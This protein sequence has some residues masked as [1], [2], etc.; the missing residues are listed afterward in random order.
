[1]KKMSYLRSGRLFLKEKLE[2]RK[3]VVFSETEKKFKTS[4]LISGVSSPVDVEINYTS[5][6]D[7][8]L[9]LNN[10]RIVYSSATIG[11]KRYDNLYDRLKEK[12]FNDETLFAP[13]KVDEGY[14]YGRHRAVDYYYSDF[15]RHVLIEKVD[16]RN[17]ELLAFE[18]YFEDEQ[19]FRQEYFYCKKLKKLFERVSL[20]PEKRSLPEEKWNDKDYAKFL[21]TL[22]LTDDFCD[23]YAIDSENRFYRV[24]NVKDENNIRIFMF[25]NKNTSGKK[26]SIMTMR[27]RERIYSKTRGDYLS[28]HLYDMYTYRELVEKIKSDKL[29]IVEYKDEFTVPITTSNITIQSPRVMGEEV[30]ALSKGTWVEISDG[31]IGVISGDLEGKYYPLILEGQFEAERVKEEKHIHNNLT[32]LENQFKKA[33][34]NEMVSFKVYDRLHYVY[35]HGY[36][37]GETPKFYLVKPLHKIGMNKAVLVQKRLILSL[38]DYHNTLEDAMKPIKEIYGHDDFI[39]VPKEDI[40]K[41]NEEEQGSILEYYDEKELTLELKMI[42]NLFHLGGLPVINHDYLMI[43][44][45]FYLENNSL[46]KIMKDFTDILKI[47]KNKSD[48]FDTFMSNFKKWTIKMDKV[49]NLKKTF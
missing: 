11:K 22:P 25:S 14:V 32:T 35:G 33:K 18:S 47:K 13:H 9:Q 17:F 44:L 41:I 29:N 39:F 31:N 16:E 21:E 23:N 30:D 40:Q 46:A 48:N 1:M 6:F 5:I 20:G 49:S 28:R 12:F 34:G 10:C 27:C 8:Y 7:K 42:E 4:V 37:L 15:Y 19:L 38:R 43:K 26:T 24:Y 3:D 2:E 45:N 36:V